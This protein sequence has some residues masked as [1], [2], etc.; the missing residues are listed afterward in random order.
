MKDCPR[1]SSNTSAMPASKDPQKQ[2][3]KKTKLT[4]GFGDDEANMQDDGKHANATSNNHNEEEKLSEGNDMSEESEEE[5]VAD[6]D[7]V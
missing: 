6:S 1:D 4:D 2:A 5:V 7:E 3:Q